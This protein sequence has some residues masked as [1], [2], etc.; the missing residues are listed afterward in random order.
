MADERRRAGGLLDFRISHE[1]RLHFSA[2]LITILL[3]SGRVFAGDIEFD[4][5]ITQEEF[6][7][8]SQ[9]VG[10]AIF[11]SPLDGA[12]STSLLGFDLGIAAT[13]VPIDE[14]ASFWLRSVGNSNLTRS[15][16][17]IVPRLVAAK[18]I[19]VLRISASLA[20]VPD[21]DIQVYGGSVDLPLIR[22]GLLRPALSLR[23]SYSQLR[24]IEIYKAKTYGAEVFLSKGFGPV[25]PYA[26][27]GMMRTNAT[28][29]IPLSLVPGGLTRTLEDESD[30]NRF[31]LGVKV[32]I[33]LPK[34]V[35]EA[36][37][38]KDRTYAAK[39]SL[40]L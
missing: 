20:K 1:Q 22:G 9:S 24:G 14:T 17:L 2:V 4:P 26:G 5:A 35:I 31:T 28:G 3:A 19:G 32:S 11:A 25:T 13:A 39:V 6:S 30:H 27:V 29:T 15:G 10:Q 38:G 8:F 7:E 36:T 40:G 12:A 18:G 23:G 37:Q 33:L 16:Y 21:S 34:I